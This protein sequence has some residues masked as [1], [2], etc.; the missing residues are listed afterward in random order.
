MQEARKALVTVLTEKVLLAM[1][2]P[3]LD[4]VSYRLYKDFKCYIPDC[5]ENPERLKIVLKDL[6][7]PSHFVVVESIQKDLEEFAY[8]KSVENFLNVL[9]A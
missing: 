9:R 7:G 1:G 3:V 4:E 6:F 2:K 5:Y 8:N